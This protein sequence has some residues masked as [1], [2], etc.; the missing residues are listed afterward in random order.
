MPRKRPSAEPISEIRAAV[1]KLFACGRFEAARFAL[2]TIRGAQLSMTGEIE[3]IGN[4][5][6][7]GGRG[8]ALLETLR[9]YPALSKMSDGT[10]DGL[11]RRGRYTVLTGEADRSLALIGAAVEAANRGIVKFV[12]AADTPAEREQLAR[13]LKLMRAELGGISVTEYKPGSYDAVSLYKASA[14]LFDYLTAEEPAILLLSRDC[15]SRQTNILRRTADGT[16]MSS[17]VALTHPVV[18]TSTE[19]VEAGRKLASLA[20]IFEPTATVVIAGEEKNLRDAV[21]YRPD[22]PETDDGGDGAE[23][24]TIG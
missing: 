6:S 9:T 12:I 5:G 15:F 18:L 20:A 17:L 24:L 11:I 8:T 10:I 7:L 16:S 14:S 2:P 3:G 19:T 21:L 23:Q 22:E 1:G 4:G 13:K